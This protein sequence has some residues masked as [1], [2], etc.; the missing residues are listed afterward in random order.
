MRTKQGITNRFVPLQT[1]V[2]GKLYCLRCQHYQKNVGLL[3]RH[4]CDLD[5]NLFV[6]QIHEDASSAICMMVRY[7]HEKKFAIVLVGDFFIRIDE[8]RQESAYKTW[9]E[10]YDE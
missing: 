1:A 4:K 7:S 8:P 3:T 10:S 2:V 6:D 9:L 5:G